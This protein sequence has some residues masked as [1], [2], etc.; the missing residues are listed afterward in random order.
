MI[1]FDVPFFRG[2][3]L[4]LF[5]LGIHCIRTVDFSVESWGGYQKFCHENS[6]SL[7]QN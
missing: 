4:S 6:L 3:L 1:F 5:V 7:H 2:I